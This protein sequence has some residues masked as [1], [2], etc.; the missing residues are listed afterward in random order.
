MTT[1]LRSRST[2][3]DGMQVSTTVETNDL[4][5]NR[6]IIDRLKWPLIKGR[7][8]AGG[9]LPGATNYSDYLF[10]D[11]TAFGGAGLWEVGGDEVHLGT[12]AGEINQGDTAVA[13]GKSA[14]NDNQ[15]LQSVA[16]GS[17]AGEIKQSAN[18]V[19][20]GPDAIILHR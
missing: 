6:A 18:S 1:N 13:I 14:G 3:F 8:Q 7:G 15:G 17:N 4:T 2:N 16:I 19:A 5:A 10:W 20:I 11:P 9:L 12:V